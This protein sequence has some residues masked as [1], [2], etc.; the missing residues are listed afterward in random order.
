MPARAEG[1]CFALQ[2]LAEQRQ[3]LETQ[4]AEMLMASCTRLL[5]GASQEL[6]VQIMT[7]AS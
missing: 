5:D 1:S 7:E 6:T 4:R 3:Q 2:V